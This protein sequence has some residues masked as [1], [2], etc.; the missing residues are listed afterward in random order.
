MSQ[1]LPSP[2]KESQHDS[3]KGG[4]RLQT[5]FTVACGLVW[6]GLVPQDASGRAAWLQTALPFHPVAA[7]GPQGMKHVGA[8][9]RWRAGPTPMLLPRACPC[10]SGSPALCVSM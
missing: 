1:C 3:V 7:R 8:E 6:A 2:G 10:H 4:V 5:G 9:G